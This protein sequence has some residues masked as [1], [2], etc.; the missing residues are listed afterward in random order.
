MDK[1][2]R[3]HLSGRRNEPKNEEIEL[4]REDMRVREER[5]EERKQDDKSGEYRTCNKK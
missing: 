4:E 2:R 5:T 3:P 1:M